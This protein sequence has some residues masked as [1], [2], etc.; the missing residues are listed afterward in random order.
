MASS[1]SELPSSNARDDARTAAACA[2]AK[3]PAAPKAACSS[4]AVVASA[5]CVDAEHA[6]VSRRTAGLRVSSSSL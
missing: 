1:G 3:A 4:A 2:A 5:A 6:I